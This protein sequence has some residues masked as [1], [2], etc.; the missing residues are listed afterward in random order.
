[1]K[2]KVIIENEETTIVL[3]PENEFEI[4]IIEKT[5]KKKEKFNMAL[6]VDA[7]YNYGTYSNHKIVISIQKPQEIK[8]AISDKFKA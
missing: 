6:S 1:M 4:D 2:A 8:Q 5:H 7:Q 3:T